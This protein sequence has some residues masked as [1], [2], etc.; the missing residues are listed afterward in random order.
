MTD[1]DYILNAVLRIL[2]GGLFCWFVLR[3]IA[4]EYRE[5]LNGL[6]QMRKY[7]LGS[8]V[9]FLA[10]SE[11]GTVFFILEGFDLSH[12]VALATKMVV[13]FGTVAFMFGV[14]SWVLICNEKE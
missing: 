14:A 13:Y 5:R 8:L 1:F 11:A 4:K 12:D 3:V 10:F 2:F 7:L 6:R 9:S